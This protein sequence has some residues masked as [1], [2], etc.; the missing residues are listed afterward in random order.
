MS[1]IERKKPPTIA[2][3]MKELS[4]YAERVA[5]FTRDEAEAKRAG[6]MARSFLAQA[7][8]DYTAGREALDAALDQV[9]PK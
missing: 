7:V 6:D 5:Q 4:T 9:V 1:P 3:L 8:K 2:E